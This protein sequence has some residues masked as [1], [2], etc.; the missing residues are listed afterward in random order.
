M[1]F[2]RETRKKKGGVSRN[3][4]WKRGEVARTG[5]GSAIVKRGATFLLDEGGKKKNERRTLSCL[6]GNRNPF[7]YTKKK[8]EACFTNTFHSGEGKKRERAL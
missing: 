7:P 5:R 8:K 4:R 6:T 2:S 3:D 1:M